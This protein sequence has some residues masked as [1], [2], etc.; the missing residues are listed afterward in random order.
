[1]RAVRSLSIV[2]RVVAGAYV[3]FMAVGCESD[4]NA[5]GPNGSAG[6]AAINEIVTDGPI[7]ASSSDTLVAFN[8]TTNSVVPKSGDWDILLRRYE[9]RLNSPATAGASTKNVTAFA[10]GN[11]KTAD[12]TKILSFTIDNTKIAFDTVRAASI[13]ADASFSSDK[14]TENKNAYLNLNGAPTV[15]PAN[16][17]KIR[18]ANGGY[19]LV[20]ATVVTYTQALTSITLETRVQT[21]TTLGAPQTATVSVAAGAVNFSIVTN[22]VVTASGCNWDLN[23]SPSF[24]ITT[25]SACSVGTYPGATSPTFAATT[26]ASD[27]PQYVTG[28]TELSGPIPNSVTDSIAPF[29]YNLLGT[30]RLH[31]MFNTYL[32]KSAGKVFKL[33]VINYYSAAGASG[34][35]T[36]RVARIQ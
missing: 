8:L 10:V 35:P 6:E 4:A 24:D 31:P 13:P 27:A 23:I 11:N 29:R 5:T 25:N 12:S 28:L 32:I 2:A 34:F 14:L 30:N 18:T 19:A 15:A 22:S 16:Y 17:W 26:S 9:I 33:Q 21:G 7:D 36:L 20:H 1:M 3:V